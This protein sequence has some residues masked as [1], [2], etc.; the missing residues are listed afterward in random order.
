MYELHCLAANSRL[1]RA[2]PI[3]VSVEYSEV[4]EEPENE[5]YQT[6]GLYKTVTGIVLKVDHPTQTITIFAEG[7]E[8]TIPFSDIYRIADASGKMDPD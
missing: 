2:N 8:R 1:I 7:E 4:C 6:K 5:A 3:S